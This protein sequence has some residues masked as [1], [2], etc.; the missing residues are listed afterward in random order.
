MRPGRL[1]EL[2]WQ[3]DIQPATGPSARRIQRALGAL[4]PLRTVL[5]SAAYGVDRSYILNEE[6]ELLPEV[7]LG[8]VLAEELSIEVPVGSLVVFSDSDLLFDSL[9]DD[10]L[11]YDLGVMVVEALLGVIGSRIFS[12]EQETAALYAM[13]Y[14]YH[15]MIDGSGFMHLGLV[16]A[17]FR[18]GL[19]AGL[20]TY[21]TGSQ[22]AR[23]DTSSLFLGPDFLNCPHLLDY[24]RQ[25]D[26]N[27]AAPDRIPAGLM[28]FVGGRC[29]YDAWVANIRNAVTAKLE[30]HTAPTRR[31][32]A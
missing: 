11:S 13:A 6:T 9:P 27:F 20:C 26:G 21:W 18:A 30:S 10:E 1:L 16:P 29:G 2:I 15:S 19:A 22:S 32:S 28:Q 5:L 12:L 4:L 8:D 23:S 14:S 24:L 31:A 17:Q 25:L 3:G 7:S